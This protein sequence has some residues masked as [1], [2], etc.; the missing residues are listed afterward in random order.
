MSGQVLAIAL[1]LASASPLETHWRLTPDYTLVIPPDQAQTSAPIAPPM[2]TQPVWRAP[3]LFGQEASEVKQGLYASPTQLTGAFSV[4]MWV[5]DHVNHPVGA[6]AAGVAATGET[7]WTLGYFSELGNDKF[8]HGA[9]LHFGPIELRPTAKD[10]AHAPWRRYLH[11]LVGAFDGRTWRLFHNGELVGEADGPAASFG[12]INL[13]GYLGAE[14]YMKLPN[15]VRDVWMHD[16]AFSAAEVAAAFSARQH[17]ITQATRGDAPGLRFTAGPYLTPP[18]TTNQSL[19]WETNLPATGL[20]EWGETSSFSRRT[21][22]DAA[23]R[24]HRTVMSDLKP[25][26]VYFYRVTAHIADGAAMDSGV[27][28]FRTMPAAGSPL[29]FALTGD[30]QER[31]FINFRLSQEIWRQRPHFLLIAGDLVGGEED[32]RRWHWTD[33]YFVGMGPLVAR[34][35][36]LA[37]RGNGDI[38]LVDAGTDRRVFDSFD[39]YHNQPDDGRGHF[40]H[41]IG[42]IDFFILDGNLAMRERWEPGF[43]ARQRAWLERALRS[44]TARWKIAVHHQPAYSSDDDDY[45]DGYAGPTTGGDPEIRRDFVDLYERYG[46]DLVVSG[47]IHSY[48]RS[49]PLRA[50]KPACGGVTYLQAGGGGGDTERA[51]PAH[52]AIMASAYDGFHYVLARVF[53]DALEIEMHDAD[54]R[55]RDVATLA[56]HAVTRR[57]CAENR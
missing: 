31:P 20:L 48:A 13:A 47:H 12:R 49:W 16:H 3:R 1:Q 17:E 14:P 8:E 52:G 18:G 5:S 50:G 32:E 7:A 54:G 44:S 25:D 39:R 11:H 51:M 4:E 27:L 24:L 57:R 23:D 28:S 43:R 37:A 41:R 6:L 22:F 56:P 53:G 33:E 40:R 30:T 2:L 35:P 38:D 10:S 19:L 9:A 21:T 34:T 26:T 45:G 29:V 42:D 46:V 36:T 15:L 55:L